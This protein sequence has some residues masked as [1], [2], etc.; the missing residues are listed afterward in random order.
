MADRVAEMHL[1]WEISR[2]RDE[3]AISTWRTIIAI[4]IGKERRRDVTET[5]TGIGT[6]IG[7]GIAIEIWIKIGIEAEIAIETGDG[8][9]EAE[10]EGGMMMA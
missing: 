10:T 1:L 4:T 6:G 3:L 9:C 8:T 2:N 5:E 7:T